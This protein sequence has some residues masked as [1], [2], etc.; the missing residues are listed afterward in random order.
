MCS[1][2]FGGSSKVSTPEI[3]QVAPA[4][5]NVTSSDISDS[6]GS[7]EANKRQRAKRGYAATR[8]ASDTLAG[9]AGKTTLG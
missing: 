6:S 3:T 5:T 2:L 4:A 7:G 1:S 9:S 8:L